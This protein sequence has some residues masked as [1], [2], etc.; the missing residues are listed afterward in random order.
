MWGLLL[1]NLKSINKLYAMPNSPTN[2]KVL[3][4][5]SIFFFGD[6]FDGFCEVKLIPAAIAPVDN[7]LLIYVY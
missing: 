1:I 2:N 5:T 3:A 7:E 6:E 4:D